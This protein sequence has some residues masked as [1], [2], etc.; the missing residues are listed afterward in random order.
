MAE[1]DTRS[2]DPKTDPGRIRDGS[3][4]EPGRNRDGVTIN[5][6]NKNVI[7]IKKTIIIIVGVRTRGDCYYGITKIRW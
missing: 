4:T 5:D 6:Y 1:K 2:A 3:G 7:L